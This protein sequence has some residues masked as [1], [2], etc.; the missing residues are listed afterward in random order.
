MSAMLDEVRAAEPAAPARIT[1]PPQ[2]DLP[3]GYTPR[4]NVPKPKPAKAEL[5]AAHPARKAA[6]A[7]AAKTGAFTPEEVARAK[8]RLAARESAVES[9]PQ[10]IDL[11]QLPTSWRTRTDQPIAR[12]TKAEVS[13]MADAMTAEGIDAAEAMRAVASNPQLPPQV[14]TELMTALGKIAKRN[15]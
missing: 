7:K 1:T 15:R 5:P 6:E 9:V 11:Q 8:A 3:A 14:R 12:V 10:T 2:A 13:Q 4:T